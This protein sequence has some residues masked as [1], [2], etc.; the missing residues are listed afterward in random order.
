MKVFAAICLLLLPATA[1]AQ[2]VPDMGDMD[3]QKMMQQAQAIQACMQ[4]VDQGELEKFQQQAMEINK[5][6]KSLCKAGKRE[7]A[8]KLAMSFGKETENNTAMQ[9]MKKCG[10]MAQ[11][12]MPSV[13]QTDDDI[14]Y[15]KQ[16]V[17][18]S[19]GE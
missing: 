2:N 1:L 17:C 15:S 7:Q 3:V 9:E 6:I 14:D 10:E 13:A 4:N 11:T 5:E 16:H 19:L 8:Q 12:I 18:D